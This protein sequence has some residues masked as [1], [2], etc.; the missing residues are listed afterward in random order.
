MGH[1]G[2]CDVDLVQE[3]RFFQ[4]SIDAAMSAPCEQEV[5]FFQQMTALSPTRGRGGPVQR[6]VTEP[7]EQSWGSQRQRK[8]VGFRSKSDGD[9]TGQEGFW[10]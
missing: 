8:K 5:R 9:S 2:E 7:G 4:H 1:D 6:S 3:D 10:A